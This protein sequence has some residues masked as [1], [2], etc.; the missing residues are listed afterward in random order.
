MHRICGKVDIPSVPLISREAH[1]L[2]RAYTMGYMA[3]ER[4][5]GVAVPPRA[6]PRPALVRGRRQARPCTP[7]SQPERDVSDGWLEWSDAP[8]AVR[9]PATAPPLSDLASSLVSSDDAGGLSSL[10]RDYDYDDDYDRRERVFLVAAALKRATNSKSGQHSYSIMESLEELGRLAETAGLEVVGYTYQMLDEL[11]P[12]TYVNTGK[13]GEIAKAIADTGAETVLFDDELSPGQMRN[14]ERALGKQG[15]RLC[16][17]TALILDIFSQRA[18]TREGKLQVE[19]AQAEYQLPRLTRMWSH[20][21]RQSGGGQVKGMGEKQIEVDRRLLR[22]QAA[23]LR[24][25]LEDIRGHRKGY[26]DRRAA[27]PIPVVALVGYTNAGK[28]S[29]LNTITDAG[30]LAE[31][32]LFATLDPTTRRV[33]LPGGQEVLFSDTV[34]FIQRLPTQL[35]A[36]FRATLE[37]IKDASLLL[38]VVDASHPN[39]AAQVDAVN[40]V[41]DELEVQNIPSLTVWNKLDACSNPQAV[42][43]VGAG[44][45]E[46]VCVSATQPYGIDD[47]LEAILRQ[48]QKKMTTMMVLVPYAK[49][50]LVDEIYR[51]GVVVREAFTEV[52]T[53]MHCHV[54][55]HLAGKLDPMQISPES[56]D[57]AYES[58]D[59]DVVVASETDEDDQV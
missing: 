6:L 9:Q 32:Q 10:S 2:I 4:L 40:R 55:V 17:R 37:E 48:L 3:S 53:I 31:D 12:R 11:N 44:R 28:S 38:H 1:S 22:N 46:T 42:L 5:P 25:Q 21:E 19:L 26:R 43:S 57:S 59:L 39:A 23:K 29:L 20:L 33:V 56:I 16:E 30:V 27:A 24:R 8:E 35:I 47:L 51:A 13:V 18:R 52:G 14:L 54:P 36:A 45:K 34:G 58:M 15:V 49:G 41:L 7:R 50:E